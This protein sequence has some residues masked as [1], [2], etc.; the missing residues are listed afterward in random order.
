MCVFVCVC[1][2]LSCVLRLPGSLALSSNTPTSSS[3][4]LTGLAGQ[5]PSPTLTQTQTQTQTTTRVS[6]VVETDQKEEQDA[7]RAQQ[8]Q[9]LQLDRMKLLPP[10]TAISAPGKTV[11]KLTKSTKNL[12]ALSN[13]K[14]PHSSSSTMAWQEPKPSRSASEGSDDWGDFQVNEGTTRHVSPEKEAV[15]GSSVVAV[16]E[17]NKDVTVRSKTCSD[18][19]TVAPAYMEESDG[20][21]SDSS[22]S[23]VTNPMLS[24]LKLDESSS[25]TQDQEGANM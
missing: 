13:K 7:S 14:K 16:A 8:Q 5:M 19:S 24:T 9:Q 3:D 20:S 2:C 22:P 4:N 6:V 11:P 1:L 12:P 15:G 21:D 10:I 17:V 23:A 18:V 25:S